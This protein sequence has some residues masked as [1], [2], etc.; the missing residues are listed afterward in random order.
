MTWFFYA[1][2]NGARRKLRTLVTAGGVALAVAALFSLISFQRGYQSGLR[3]ELDKLGAHI[4]IAPKGCPYNAASIALH[5]ASWPCFLKQ[6]YLEQVRQTPG[7]NTAAPMFM[8]AIYDKD[9]KQ[10][11]YVGADPSLLKLKREWKI[12]GAFPGRPEECLL[13]SSVA[14]SLHASPGQQIALPALDGKHARVSGVIQTTNGEDDR[15]IYLPLSTAQ[16]DFHRSGQLTHILV[17]LTDPDAMDVVVSGLRA[18]EA[19]LD[20]NVVPLTHLFRSIQGLVNSTRM[21]LGCVALIAL[22][23]AGAGVSNTVLMAVTERTR[24]IGVMRAVG[25]SQGDIF[26]LIWLETV[27]VCL[28]GALIGIL[29]AAFASGA[30]ESWLRA[31]LPF[32]PNDALVRPELAVALG[33]LAAAAALGTV[34]GLLPAWR[35]ARLS[36]VE[37][38]S[39]G[40]R[41]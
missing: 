30:V 7:I 20:M 32:S 39:S 15:F 10:Y 27:Q 12:T 36:P 2:R 13:G 38:I 14:A 11:V 9:D 40:S 17:R 3:T 1:L 26:R 41:S 19:G 6:S 18:C 31:R 34:A 22:L 23:I 33:C 5:G 25:A 16:A 28:G 21:L 4:L 35:A 8:N 29:L 37:A 24:E